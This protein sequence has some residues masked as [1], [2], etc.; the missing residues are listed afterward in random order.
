MLL[1]YYNPGLFSPRINLSSTPDRA[2]AGDSWIT[3]FLIPVCTIRCDSLTL[4]TTARAGASVI[5]QWSDPLEAL[6]WMFGTFWP[7]EGRWIGYLSYDLGR[8]FKALPTTAADDLNLPLFVFTYCRPTG[9]RPGGAEPDYG[10]RADRLSSDFTRGQYE[11]AVVRVMN[12]IAAG[13]V[14]QV[15][16]AQRFTAGLRRIPRRFTAAS[17]ANRH[18]RSGRISAM[19][20]SRLFPTLPSYFSA[21]RP[22][23]GLSPARSRGRGRPGRGWMSSCAIQ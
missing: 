19:K 23:G 5:R 16:L 13:D 1:L 22:I 9:G 12:Y 3:G 11:D 20:I 2:E 18:P 6:L 21:S 8:L 14:F 17:S 10:I 4:K 7:G 15:N